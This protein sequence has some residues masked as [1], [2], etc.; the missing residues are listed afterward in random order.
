[1]FALEN[2]WIEGDEVNRQ[3][4]VAGLHQIEITFHINPNEDGKQQLYLNGR[5]VEQEIR[6]MQ[7]A[8]S[9][10]RVAAISEVRKKLV[11]MQRAMGKLGGIVMDGRDIGSVVFPNADLKFFVT[12]R[13]E[14][15]AARRQAELQQKGE[16]HGIEEIKMNLLE[17]DRMDTS[18]AD[19]PLIQTV[20]AILIDT[21]DLTRETQLQLAL[22]HVNSIL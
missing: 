4:L 3:A 5:N 14:I 19:S 6:G 10:S 2:N 15:R 16:N 1:M 8:N 7:V 12:A 13:P 18:R 9:V 20:D 22:N 17:R 11:E 21:S